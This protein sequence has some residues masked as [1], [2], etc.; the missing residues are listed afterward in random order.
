MKIGNQTF[1][2]RSI[3]EHVP[4]ESTFNLF[5]D[6]ILTLR[7]FRVRRFAFRNFALVLIFKNGNNFE[8]PKFEVV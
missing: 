7:R 2:T 1:N 5:I 6:R 4:S 8:Y 3:F